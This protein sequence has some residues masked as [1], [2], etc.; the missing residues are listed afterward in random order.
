[1]TT[2]GCLRFETPPTWRA[3][4]PY[5]YPPGTGWLS[6]T[7]RHSVPFSS[8]P[9][10]CRT[11]VE[12]IDPASTRKSLFLDKQCRRK[13]NLRCGPTWREERQT[14][15]LESTLASSLQSSGSLSA[16][17]CGFPEILRSHV[18]I[19]PEAWMCQ[20]STVLS[21]QEEALRWADP[22]SRGPTNY[23]TKFTVSNLFLNRNRPDDLMHNTRR[24]LY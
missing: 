1:M 2:F 6:Y 3:M 22:Q 17:A 7:P 12:V 19:P 13:W 11:T 16:C 23:L 21:W 5:L 24:W 10:T 4:S 20:R 15:P 9:T 14:H 8:P 18:N